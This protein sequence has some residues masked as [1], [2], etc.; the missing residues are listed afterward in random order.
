MFQSCY[1]VMGC[2]YYTQIV[3]IVTSELHFQLLFGLC[4]IVLNNLCEISIFLMLFSVNK[5]MLLSHILFWEFNVKVI[6]CY[7]LYRVFKCYL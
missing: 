1:Y 3:K 4:K 2:V 7:V 6:N 5:Y